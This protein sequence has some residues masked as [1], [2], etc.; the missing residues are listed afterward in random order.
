MP[1][2]KI[3]TTDTGTQIPLGILRLSIPNQIPTLDISTITNIIVT[4]VIRSAI[5][6]LDINSGLLISLNPT[7]NCPHFWQFLGLCEVS[8]ISLQFVQRISDFELFSTS[9]LN[10]MS[11]D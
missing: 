10:K 1:V 11:I 8:I 4:I 7:T 9:I 6:G 2:E 3:N 5:A